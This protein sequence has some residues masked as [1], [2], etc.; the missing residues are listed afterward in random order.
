M[1]SVRKLQLGKV[2]SLPLSW[3]VQVGGSGLGSPRGSMIRPGFCSLPTTPTT[4]RVPTR[5]GLGY[6]DLWDKSLEEEPAMERVESGRDL[7]AKMLEKLS[8]ENS[9]DRV[10]QDPGQS[11]VAPDVEWVSDLIR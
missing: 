9:L 1:T 8:K 6:V 10:R 4:I 5:S 3:N 7:R 11:I 2:K